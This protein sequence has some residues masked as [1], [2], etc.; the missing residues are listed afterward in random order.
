MNSVVTEVKEVTKLELEKNIERLQSEMETKMRANLEE[1]RRKD[2]DRHAQEVHRLETLM[3]AVEEEKAKMEADMSESEKAM[4]MLL[5][6]GGSRIT[7]V[8]L[9]LVP[10]GCEVRKYVEQLVNGGTNLD[11]IGARTSKVEDMGK[12]QKNLLAN[13]A[14]IA[15][16]EVLV[17]IKAGEQDH[18]GVLK[19]VMD[20]RGSSST[21][22][23]EA[24]K[25]FQSSDSNPVL[26]I[27]FTGY[28]NLDRMGLRVR[29]STLFFIVYL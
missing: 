11:N 14:S 18:P 7:D 6:E 17:L 5:E 4:S 13:V 2:S 8:L 24:I 12:T 3:N 22:L 23:G 20:L 10:R 25:Q 1:Q 16:N 27:L 19:A 9:A 21:P 26:N 15:L 28:Q 29:F